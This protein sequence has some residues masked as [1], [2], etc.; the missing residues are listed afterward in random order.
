MTPTVSVIIP[1]YNAE[2]YIADTLRSALDQTWPHVEV[3][4][5]DD[6]SKDGTLARAAEFGDRVRIHQQANGGVARAR[7]NGVGLAR[8]EWIAF[9][10]ADDLWR[11]E[12]IEKQLACSDAPLSFTDRLNFGELDGLPERQSL[13]TPMQGG[14]IFAALLLKG[15]FITT[16]SVMMRRD[17]FLQLG[18]FD[19]SFNGT[20]DWNLWLRVAEQHP[21]GFCPAPLVRYRLHRGGLSRNYERINRERQEVITRALNTPRGR[22]LDALTKRR[23]WA[24]TWAANGFDARRAGARARAFGD[25]MRSAVNWPL[26]LQV[27]KEAVKVCLNA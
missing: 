5:V 23:I 13:V 24:Q 14:D 20:E 27:Y 10:D 19:L 1:A 12:K 25:Y 11:P 2:R 7:N 18:G 21:I 4:V 6:G 26:D 16:T 15:N 8:G 9:L 17:L 3:I 22:A